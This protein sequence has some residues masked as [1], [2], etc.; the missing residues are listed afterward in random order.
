MGFVPPGLGLEPRWGQP[1]GWG[2]GLFQPA[3]PPQGACLWTALLPLTGASHH[4]RRHGISAQHGAHGWSDHEVQRC[5]RVTGKDSETEAEV[6]GGRGDR[7]TRR[8]RRHPER[9]QT[10]AG[11]QRGGETGPGPVRGGQSRRKQGGEEERGREG[12]RWGSRKGEGREGRRE[13][14]ERGGDEGEKKWRKQT[15]KPEEAPNM[16]T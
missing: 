10:E 8:Q 15:Q 12:E 16:G 5:S 1:T 4:G 7:G 3:P 2:Y 6:R 9:C 11:E 14:K 13:S